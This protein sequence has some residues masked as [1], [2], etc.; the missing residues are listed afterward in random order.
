MQNVIEQQSEETNMR[1]NKN[2][3]IR[4]ESINSCKVS[5]V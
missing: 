3:G 5:G 4:K 1:K 2:N